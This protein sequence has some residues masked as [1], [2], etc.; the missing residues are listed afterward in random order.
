[1]KKK[2]KVVH[3]Y[4]KIPN[5]IYWGSERVVL[6][7]KNPNGEWMQSEFYPM[8]Y[9]EVETEQAKELKELVMEKEKQRQTMYEH[10]QR[11]I[12]QLMNTSPM[13]G[14]PH[15]IVEKDGVYYKVQIITALDSPEGLYIKGRI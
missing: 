15:I 10:F 3:R 14:K 11:E 6:K 7:Y 4:I 9:E 13:R 8:D 5:W 2:E 1:M 12:A